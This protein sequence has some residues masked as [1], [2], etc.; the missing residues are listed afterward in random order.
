MTAPRQVVPGRESVI[1]RRCS[2]RQ[3][4]LKPSDEL[5]AVFLYLLAAIAGVFDITV[6]AYVAMSNHMHLVVRDN[7]GRLPEFLCH[8]NKMIAKVLNPFWGRTENFWSNEQVSVVHLVQANDRLEKIIYTLANPVAAHLVA[9]AQEWPGA[10]AYTQLLSGKTLTFKRPKRFFRKSSAM[11]ASA[12]LTLGRPT[13]FEALTHEQWAEKVQEGVQKAEKKAQAE[14]DEDPAVRDRFVGRAGVLAASHLQLGTRPEKRNDENPILACLN[15]E[16][17]DQELAAV[18]QFRHE[19]A[20][21]RKKYR[22]NKRDAVFPFGTYQMKKLGA[23]VRREPPDLGA[24]DAATPA[25]R[26][27]RGTNQG[28]REKSAKPDIRKSARRA[29]IASAARSRMTPRAS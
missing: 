14:R 1:T 26:A 21:A 19:H 23:R 10:T 15:G 13:G 12:T 2:Q 28:T 6:L 16:R 5:T 22:K 25:P 27:P 18:D 4:L 20:E 7:D 24:A 17:R 11:P 8:L 9:R 3:F 29:K